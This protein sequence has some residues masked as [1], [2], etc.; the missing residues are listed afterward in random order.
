MIR[1]HWLLILGL[2]ALH[3]SPG[4]RSAIDA[5][6]L[7]GRYSADQSSITFRV[8]SARATR[9][10]VFIYK[11]P[12]GAEEK[13]KYVMTRDPATSVWSRTVATSTLKN[14]HGIT[15]AVYYG[16]RAWGPN[17]TYK[18]GWSKGSLSGF[19]T[20]VDAQGNRFNPNKLLIDPYARELSHDPQT[21]GQTDG[22]LYAS[23]PGFRTIDT[24]RIAPKGI[25]LASNAAATLVK[26]TRALSED[27]IYEVHVRG[28]TMLD[29]SIPEHLRGTYAGAA[30]KAPYLAALGV[31]AI[32]FLPLQETQNDTHEVDPVTTA[33]DNYWGY[34]T[35]NFFAPERRYSSDKRPGGPTLEFSNMVKAFHEHDIKVFVDVVYN[36]T[37]EGGLY[38]G[39]E[40]STA[41]V[42]SFRGLDNPTYYSLTSDRQFYWD[43]TGTTGNYNTF[44]PVAQNLIID[45]LGYWINTLGVDGFRFDLASV[46]GNTCEHGCF[47][48]DKF[49]PGTALNRIVR[50][51]P[52]RTANG[53][54]VDWIA[55]PWAIGEGTYQVGNF[56][57][58]WAEWNDKFRDSLR[59]DQNRLGADAI[60]VGEIAARFSGSADLFQDDGRRPW[61]SINFMVA[62]DGFTLIDLYQCNSRNNSQPWPLGPSDGGSDNNNSWDQ[63][64][65]AAEQR[66]AARNGMAFLALSA[67]TP[68]LTGGDEFLRS[69]QCNNNPYNLDSPGNWLSWSWSTGQTTFKTFTQ[70]LL[71]FRKK[72][73]ALRP[74]S[75]Y[76]AQTPMRTSWSSIAG[77][78]PTATCPTQRISTIPPTTPSPGASTARSSAIRRAPSTLPTTA[79]PTA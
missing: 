74:A 59:R 54:G 49:H 48:Y 26:P 53:S 55:E 10:E 73:P 30:L 16:Y 72:H 27:V 52:A 40:A 5:Q 18:T 21:P 4:A 34:M 17:W 32:E 12:T 28:L 43:N 45:S 6:Q 31:T 51:M 29:T 8:Y 38:A 66:K 67:G 36:H 75:F 47:N 42:L 15:G 14:T 13:A 63:G 61:E 76:S 60:T 79:G 58:G 20:D 77:S 41:N 39:D 46:L 22:T 1:P 33:G 7:G 44:N 23:G 11:S 62:H 19:V 24:G 64:G 70:R 9:I 69:V 68:M 25:V 78:G 35:L 57:A 37:G 65:S 71:A 50:E 2:L 56:P 3:F